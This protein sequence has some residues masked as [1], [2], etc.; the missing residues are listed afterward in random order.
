MA[1]LNIAVEAVSSFDEA[2]ITADISIATTTACDPWVTPECFK[3]GSLF[4]NVSL[5]DPTFDM[6][7][8]ADKI[9]VDDWEQCIHSDRVLARMHRAGQV[10]RASIHAEFGEIISGKLPGRESADERIFFNPFGLA[11][12]DLAVAKMVYD[13]A[14]ALGLGERIQLVDEEW[15]VLF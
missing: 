11:I 14:L 12:E 1:G 10:D 8:L 15:D 4:L 3:E 5:M 6:V 7:G 13:R 2:L 9:V